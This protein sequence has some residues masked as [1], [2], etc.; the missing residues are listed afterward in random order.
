MAALETAGPYLL[1]KYRDYARWGQD[2]ALPAGE[3]NLADLTEIMRFVTAGNFTG[4]PAL[5]VPAGYDSMGL[6]IGVQLMGR[7]WDETLLL[8]LGKVIERAVK[9]KRPSLHFNLLD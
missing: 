3:S 6:P 7:A 5:T 1:G 8:R 4:L 2:D 9:R